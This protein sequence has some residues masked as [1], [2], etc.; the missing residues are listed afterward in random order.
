MVSLLVHKT[1]SIKFGQNISGVL[2]RSPPSQ[3]SGSSPPF[4][5][6]RVESRSRKA[7][8]SEE[9]FSGRKRRNRLDLGSKQ[10]VVDRCRCF[11]FFFLV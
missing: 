4:E 10:I 1:Q 2:P 3:R 6:R 5:L 9:L 11:F 7:E 8:T